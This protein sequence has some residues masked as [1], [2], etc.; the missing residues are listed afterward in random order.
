MDE[1]ERTVLSETKDW[2]KFEIAVANFV[3][4]LDP[5]A[6]VRHNVLLPDRNTGHPRQRDVWIEARICRIFPVRAYISCKRRSRKL[7]EQDLDAFFG[8]WRSSGAEV[9]VVYSYLGFTQPAIQKGQ[10]LGIHCCRLFSNQPPDIPE[11][12]VFQSYCCVPKGK[13]SVV[14]PALVEW[15]LNTYG[16]LFAVKLADPEGP[17]TVLDKIVS[18][19]HEEEAKI[20]QGS[21]R[22]ETFPTD[23]S[24]VLVLWDEKRE[25]R[26]LKIVINGMWE[27]YRGKMEAHLVEGSYSYTAG[28]FIGQQAG[29][30]VDML[31]PTP[32]PGWERLDQRPSTFEP[33]SVTAILYHG[34]VRDAFIK[35]LGPES[36]GGA[37]Q[38]LDGA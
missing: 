22:E 16:D 21:R 38:S 14:G 23:W 7:D 28:E 8:E 37:T 5:Q 12:L 15:G 1:S 30:A 18:V 17:S 35:A 11:V 6:D 4:A 20:V 10:A 26:P 33:N 32:G 3:A 29:P 31:G 36:L 9:G 24:A 2:E 13:M 34:N 19:F 27:I 25:R